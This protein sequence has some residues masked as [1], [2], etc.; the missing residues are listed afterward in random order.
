M[1]DCLRMDDEQDGAR[2]KGWK[3]A[4]DM[5]G[6]FGAAWRSENCGRVPG[7]Q[8]RL[9]TCCSGPGPVAALQELLLPHQRRVV[10]VTEQSTNNDV[11]TVAYR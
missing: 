8:I 4:R 6:H 1:D 7:S 3:W 2:W 10:A 9:A 11:P 5:E